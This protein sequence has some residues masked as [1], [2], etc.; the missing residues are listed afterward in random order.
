MHADRASPSCPTGTQ[1]GSRRTITSS[2]NV[3]PSAPQ[4]GSVPGAA[5]FRPR[6]VSRSAADAPRR[7]APPT[8][9]AVPGPESRGSHTP[10]AIRSGVAAPTAPAT[11][12]AAAYG[13]RRGC[14]HPA[15][16]AG[17]R[18]IA[19]S[20]SH[21][22]RRSEHSTAG[23]TS[24]AAPPADACAAR[25]PRSE[26]CRAAAD[27]SRWK[28]SASLPSGRAPSARNDMPPAAPEANVW[29][30]RRLPV[31]PPAVNAA[32]TVPIPARPSVIW[33][34][35]GRRRSQ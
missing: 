13:R 3:M 27:A 5:G 23:A 32:R 20:A 2:A 31:A 15:D 33:C 7:G 8:A 22:A 11:G 28:R 12:A 6:P 30:A 4:R 25:R 9:P 14:V 1:P 34:R 18:T 24:H 21:A 35:C 29:I 16:G 17:R 10:A 19:P 26:A